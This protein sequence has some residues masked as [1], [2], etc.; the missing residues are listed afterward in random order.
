[1]KNEANWDL[2]DS[3][4]GH[5]EAVVEKLGDSQNLDI[6]RSHPYGGQ[7]QHHPI[8]EGDGSRGNFPTR[9]H[10]PNPVSQGMADTLPRVSQG[11][12]NLEQPVAEGNREGG[13]GTA[14]ISGP[15]AGGLIATSYA[16]PGFFQDSMIFGPIPG[17]VAENLAFPD[18]W[19]MAYLEGY[20][21]R[22][23]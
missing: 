12:L 9:P 18:L 23:C 16:N 14:V 22:N 19:Q 2:A 7:A 11:P 10:S 13:G 4:L 6:W 3:C 1:M 20:N 15:G 17:N 21:Y 5:C 8:R